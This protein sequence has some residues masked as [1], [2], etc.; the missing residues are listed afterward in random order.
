MKGP[1]GLRTSCAPGGERLA[2]PDLDCSERY[3][4]LLNCGGH[5]LLFTRWEGSDGDGLA[6]FY[7]ATL[8]RTRPA[9]SGGPFSLPTVSLPSSWNMSHNAAFA[10]GEEPG[11]VLAYGGRR[12]RWGWLNKPFEPGILRAVGHMTETGGVHWERP[13]LVISPTRASCRED[14]S[15]VERTCEFDGKLSLVPSFGGQQLLYARANL[16]ASGGRH[17]QVSRSTDGGLHWSPFELL[18]IDGVTLRAD[19][20]IYFFNAHLGRAQHGTQL[21][22]LMPAVLDGAG[23]VYLSSSSDGVAWSEPRR[24]LESEPLG[25]GRTVDHPVHGVGL[26][27]ASETQTLRFYVQHSIELG[28]GPRHDA[29]PYR[30]GLRRPCEQEGVE[31]FVCVYVAQ[32]PPPSS[33]ETPHGEEHARPRRHM[34]RGP[35]TELRL[36]R[37]RR[38][39]H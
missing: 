24:L 3:A 4:T 37:Q 9:K 38:P 2:V 13:A 39:L 21:L 20:N 22:G 11:T 12:R 33:A 35:R 18:T 14:R 29:W 30:P 15:S 17:V 7:W 1:T 23:G 32:L 27:D 5:S 10:C 28:H 34:R 8:L 6:G 26:D 36:L 16:G 19:N 25:E 31:P